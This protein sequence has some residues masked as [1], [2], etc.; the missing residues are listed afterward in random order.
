[1]GWTRKRVA[2]AAAAYLALLATRPTTMLL[3]KMAR[4]LARAF[5]ALLPALYVLFESLATLLMAVYPLLVLVGT[6][7]GGAVAVMRIWR[8]VSA[9]SA[10]DPLI[11]L[12]DA[13]R[14]H[15][16]LASALPYLP[17]VYWLYDAVTEVGSPWD[18]TYPISIALTGVATT[19]L[20]KLLLR[21]LD[22]LESRE[23]PPPPQVAADETTFRAVAVTRR[24]QAIVASALGLAV[25]MIGFISSVNLATLGLGRLGLLALVYATLLGVTA[26]WFQLA[27]TIRVGRDGV[28]IQ[29]TSKTRFHA[30]RDFDAVRVSGA[31]I[32]LVRGGKT[33]VRLQLHGADLHRGAFL[34]QRIELALAT[35]SNVSGAES[36]LAHGASRLNAH[37][38]S[39]YRSASLTREQLWDLVE[40]D[41]TAGDARTAAAQMLAASLDPSDRSRLRF[42]AS[43]TAD[44]RVRIALETVA[45]A[46]L[47]VQKQNGEADDEVDPA[48]ARRRLVIP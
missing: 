42:A 29:G 46:E 37:G 41:G 3:Q 40:A 34:A 36:L 30:Y 43:H 32:H 45:G 19:I 21:V 47:D 48:A 27:S 31:T 2:F 18:P 26:R 33:V 15:P 13:L 24:S 1:M 6:L 8:R 14:A 22:G 17:W 4:A 12:R 7:F 16:Q 9:G 35:A 44:P 5:P 39:D 25:G 20:G 38:A 10:R 11:E 23:A 28:F